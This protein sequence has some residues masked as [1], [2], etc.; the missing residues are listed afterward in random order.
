MHTDRRTPLLN[1]MA[2]IK[3]SWLFI[4][5]QKRA[6][7]SF[8][9]SSKQFIALILLSITIKIV[10]QILETGLHGEI[11]TDALPYLLY[12]IPLILLTGWAAAKAAGD[13][14][15]TL[16]AITALACVN[17]GITVLYTG[18]TLLP[19]R[20]WDTLGEMAVPVWYLPLTWS[21]LAGVVAINRVCHIAPEQRV[22]TLLSVFYLLLLPQYL[23]DEND[24]LWIPVYT[25]TGMQ[26]E[27]NR[28]EDASSE[29]MLYNQHALLD[30][31]LANITARD[32]SN[33]PHLY[34]VSVAGYG[35]QN[36]FMR[37][38]LQVKTLFDERFG[39][40]NSSLVLINNPETVNQYS[41]ATVTAI[42]RSLI[43]IGRK[44]NKENDILF[45]FMTS[46]G[47]KDY[48]FSMTMWPYTLNDMTPDV[49]LGI[50]DTAGI[51][52][53]VIV[54]SACYSGGFVPKLANENTLVMSASRD[55]RNSHG[56]SHEAE[57][58]FFGK[59]YF[60]E[61]LRNTRDFEEAFAKAKE[62]IHQR[63]ESG[64]LTHSEPQIAVGEKIRPLLNTWRE[65]Q[66]DTP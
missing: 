12:D 19:Y 23:V 28:W 2:N 53:R 33:S 59:A 7:Q 48:R 55:D 60:D 22:G 41:L 15:L 31:Q 10:F 63:E 50:L 49:L 32:N 26:E 1:L 45:L 18:L 20:I 9:P 29:K 58:T 25:E 39:T 40:T 38:A 44:M 54:V 14:S 16:K 57:W 43:N 30:A 3:A 21:G 36:V 62:A 46:H 52:N 34:L 17:L 8:R 24:N 5:L 64:K 51:K 11:N 6:V 47:A 37:E 42:Q 27:K 13:E 35:S 56:C 66:R 61:A 4:L 65:T